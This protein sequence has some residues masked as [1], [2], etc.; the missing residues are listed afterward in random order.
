MAE[1]WWPED[2]SGPSLRAWLR[3]R[4]TA[5]VFAA[6]MFLVSGPALVIAASSAGA[7]SAFP[8]A[9]ARSSADL[10]RWLGETAE[11]ATGAPWGVNLILHRSNARREA[12]L[13]AVVR[14]RA[15]LVVASVGAPDPVVGPVHDAGGVVFADVAT[16]RHA[17]KAAA[18]GVDGLV[19][20]TAGA[21]G[22][23]GWLNPFAFVAEVRRFFDGPIA[24]A[25]GIATGRALAAVEALDADLGYVG[26]PFIA[27]GESLAA[28][29]HKS[30]VVETDADGVVLT[31][32]VTGIPAN[33]QRANLVALGVLDEAGA[34]LE[35]GAL[36]IG[37]WKAAW[38]L[39]QGC[40]MVDAVRP[41]AA[42]VAELA[43]GWKAAR[44]G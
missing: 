27:T 13:A 28:E 16:L 20:L 44:R 8:A 18:A 11:G 3:A 7:L 9:N 36:D 35:R 42:V 34:V 26:T 41:A 33:F 6:P 37:S 2:R 19:L 30:A 10:D 21:G 43:A 22:N 29:A 25:G 23:A 4:L 14:A 1:A 39:G 15:P 5:P 24:V 12:D 17:R 32:A 38:S 40:G 31:D